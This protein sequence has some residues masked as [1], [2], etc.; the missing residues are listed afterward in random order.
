MVVSLKFSEKVGLR[1]AQF[2]ATLTKD[3]F[4]SEF[5]APDELNQNGKKWDCTGYYNGVRHWAIKIVH[6]VG[7]LTDTSVTCN[8]KFSLNDNCGRLY[9]KE[10]GIQRFQHRLRSLFARDYVFD[11]DMVNAHPSILHYLCKK[12]TVPCSFSCL[13]S[14]VLN[15]EQVMKANRVTK[16]DIIVALNCDKP[17]KTSNQWLKAFQAEMVGIH[18]WFFDN[19]ELFTG[20][21]YGGN[22]DNPKSSDMNRILC[23]YENQIL[24]IGINAVGRHNVHTLMFDGFHLDKDAFDENTISSL[25][26]A[27]SEFGITWKQKPFDNDVVVPQSFKFDPNL[28]MDYASRK[29]VFETKHAFIRNTASYV[30]QPPYSDEWLISKKTEF[31]DQVENF[32]CLDDEGKLVPIYNM[33]MK[34]PDRRECM[35]IDF[36]PNIDRAPPRVFNL[37][38][39]ITASYIPEEERVDTGILH[40]HLKDIISNKNEELYEYM[41]NY[42]AHMMQKLDERPNVAIILK[43]F[44]GAGKEALQRKWGAMLGEKYI[45]TTACMDDVFGTFNVKLLNKLVCTFNE[46]QGS[47]GFKYHDRIKDI[48]TEPI[49]AIRDL[50]KSHVHY[51]NCVRFIFTTNNLTPLNI[52]SNDRRFVMCAVSPDWMGNVEKWTEYHDAVNNQ[53]IIDS[54]YS[55]LMD[56]DISEFKLQTDRPITDA[57][58]ST[59]ARLIPDVYKMLRDYF[60]DETA[61]SQFAKRS[62]NGKAVWICSPIEFSNMYTQWCAEQAMNSESY[63]FK[64]TLALLCDIDSFQNKKVKEDGMMRRKYVFDQERVVAFLNQNVFKHQPDEVLEVDPLFTGCHVV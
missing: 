19:R 30:H 27:T 18:N 17:K 61:D 6:K 55:E 41:L 22:K 33:W 56:R 21:T 7:D 37:F 5:W 45:G 50:F 58:R 16:K 25:N 3:E 57:Y 10:Y 42:E 26:Q 32:L 64:R 29:K 31:K 63:N 13:E 46:A 12:N 20:I 9:I 47:E 43:G 49:L 39:G 44:E 60:I 35:K 34:D 15:R 23:K 53:L 59:Q 36:Y 51:K 4:E 40:T 54:Y 8:Y 14:Y 11:I 24:Q 28:L 52:T 48:V 38:D 1:Q 62:I 2:V